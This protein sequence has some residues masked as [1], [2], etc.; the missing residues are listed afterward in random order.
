MKYIKDAVIYKT[1]ESIAVYIHGLV[2]NGAKDAFHSALNHKLFIVTV[3]KKWGFYQDLVAYMRKHQPKI[4]LGEWIGNKKAAPTKLKP[5]KIKFKDVTINISAEEVVPSKD[6]IS[7]GEKKGQYIKLSSYHS[8]EIIEEFMWSESEKINNNPIKYTSVYNFEKN[9]TIYLGQFNSQQIQPP[10]LPKGVLEDIEKDLSDFYANSK[11]YYERG[12]PYHRGYCLYGPPGTGKSSI[13]NYL[14]NKFNRTI[15]NITAGSLSSGDISQMLSKCSG[16]SIVTVEDIDCM[17][18]GRLP[19]DKALPAFNDI[20]NA[21][22]NIC[23]PKGM[24][25]II[26]TNLIEHLDSALLRPGRIDR[27]FELTYCTNHQIQE[28]VKRYYPEFDNVR[29]DTDYTGRFTPAQIQEMLIESMSVG[30]FLERLF[31]ERPDQ[32]GETELP[33]LQ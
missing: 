26:T 9:E 8:L 31:R 33:L 19:T 24:L 6:E 14:A 5:I 18:H 25:L 27:K 11:K 3:D 28:L 2:V 7:L 29:L 13:I 23:A 30:E 16:N 32:N 17:Y 12:V 20:L 22:D 21:F 4:Q 15:Y 1:L 10:I